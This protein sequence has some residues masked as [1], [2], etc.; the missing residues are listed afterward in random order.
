MTVCDCGNRRTE[1]RMILTESSLDN[2]LCGMPN[3]IKMLYS[4]QKD[5]K[6]ATIYLTASY[7]DKT[8]SYKIKRFPYKF[9]KHGLNKITVCQNT[10]EEIP[11]NG[12]IK[13]LPL[14]NYDNVLPIDIVPDAN[15]E[16]ILPETVCAWE[17][18]LLISGK[19]ECILPHAVY[20]KID[21]EISDD[22]K[23]EHFRKIFIPMKNEE[24]PNALIWDN[25]WQRCCYWYETALREHIP[26]NS[27]FDLKIIVEDS[28]LLCR[29]T[30]NMLL[31]GLKTGN[32]TEYEEVLRR[33]LI[34]FSKNNHFI[35]AW[36]NKDD[37]SLMSLI[38][39]INKE[40]H[41]Y[42]DFLQSWY[43]ST[44][45][46]ENLMLLFENKTPTE[47]QRIDFITKFITEKYSQF[48]DKLRISSLA[49]FIA[50]NTLGMSAEKLLSNS[51]CQPLD[52]D[53]IRD[54]ASDRLMRLSD[55]DEEAFKPYTVENEA[56][57]FTKFCERANM[58][59]KQMQGDVNTNIFS[60]ESTVRRSVLYY[61][62]TFID[63]FIKLWLTKNNIR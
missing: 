36:I 42:D 56:P 11:Y 31:K 61:T 3:I 16:L 13:A 43:F 49:E 62:S 21:G 6:E 41:H 39:S 29:F 32:F 7:N 14:Y 45:D 57:N 2:L 22:E 25:T 46:T 50:S 48:M 37:Y 26:A 1:N 9:K 20:S 30:L 12:Q 10:N 52:L 35:W 18:I 55:K 27:L 54:D 40:L 59:L 33:G 19:S 47:E 58:F 23:K 4:S 15:G 28:K 38:P 8:F 60:E 17:K 63:P 44:M 5:V 34:E 51:I 24:Y 53:E